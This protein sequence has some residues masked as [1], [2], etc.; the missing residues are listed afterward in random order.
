M[1]KVTTKRTSA[2]KTRRQRKTVEK[3]YPTY[4]VDICEMETLD[5]MSRIMGVAKVK[6][7]QSVAAAEAESMIDF[8]GHTADNAIDETCG[9][10]EYVINDLRQKLSKATADLKWANRPWYKKILFWQ[11]KH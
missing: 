10:Y 11:K 8:I 1:K 5:D 9:F 6:A 7:R 2:T 4:S 3:F